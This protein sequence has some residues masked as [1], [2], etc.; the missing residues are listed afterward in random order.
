MAADDRKGAYAEVEHLKKGKWRIKRDY[1]RLNIVIAAAIAIT[2]LFFFTGDLF[3]SDVYAFSPFAALGGRYDGDFKWEIFYPMLWVGYIILWCFVSGKWFLNN[4]D[5]INTLKAYRKEYFVEHNIG[6]IGQCIYGYILFM[7]KTLKYQ[8]WKLFLY[9]LADLP[10][11]LMRNTFFYVKPDLKDKIALR[12]GYLAHLD[13]NFFNQV[14]KVEDGYNRIKR[15]VIFSDIEYLFNPN[16]YKKDENNMPIPKRNKKG[17]IIYLDSTKTKIAY[18]IDEELNNYAHIKALF[19]SEKEFYDL[20]NI[21]EGYLTGSKLYDKLLIGKDDIYTDGYIRE[22]EEIFKKHISVKLSKEQQKIRDAEIKKNKAEQAKA[23]KELGITEK[24]N[25][26]NSLKSGLIKTRNK[27]NFYE[28]L[29]LVS[30]FFTDYVNKLK[31]KAEQIQKDIDDFEEIEEVPLKEPTPFEEE[32]QAQNEYIKHLKEKNYKYFQS[33]MLRED[34]EGNLKDSVYLSLN[35]WRI[36]LTDK[37]IK[38]RKY[39]KEIIFK[40]DNPYGN[41]NVVFPRVVDLCN[42]IHFRKKILSKAKNKEERAELEQAMSESTFEK[43]VFGREKYL[44]G[45]IKKN[46]AQYKMMG[47]VKSELFKKY[48]VELLLTD[49]TLVMFRELVGQY[50][51]LPAGTIVVKLES[52]DTRMIVEY[53]RQFSLIQ[54]ED[55]K[56]DGKSE[57]FNSDNYANLFFDLFAKFCD[58]NKNHI[59]SELYWKFNTMENVKPFTFKEIVDIVDKSNEN[60]DKMESI[61]EAHNVSNIDK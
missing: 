61:A 40:D 11:L 9:D 22:N 34:K 55:K 16:E 50:M 49:F 13:K 43:K 44:E 59:Y 58:D 23:E 31:S 42:D 36:Y 25:K 6:I 19:R 46:K 54:I 3:S 41:K 28:N 27:A 33:Y 24:R 7:L 2:L 37:K 38:F 29:P 26:L 8:S 12:V 5:I 30:G 21:I 35:A 15:R 53:Y 1:N 39:V 14:V 51:N 10:F 60:F 56:N 20:F 57:L 18:E 48:L 45:D 17:E 32:I 4:E 52:Y 47:Y